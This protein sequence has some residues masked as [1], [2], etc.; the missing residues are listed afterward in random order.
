[1][2]DDFLSQVER[3]FV[4]DLSTDFFG[5]VFGS[6]GLLDDHDCHLSR[7]SSCDCVRLVDHKC[8]KL[9]DDNSHVL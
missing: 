9:C 5:T 7:D 6:L 3:K 8:S 2:T 1:M 4:N